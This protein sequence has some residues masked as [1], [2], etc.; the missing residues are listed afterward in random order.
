MKSGFDVKNRKAS[1]EFAVWHGEEAIKKQDCRSR[2]ADASANSKSKA[3]EQKKR[4]LET[5]RLKAEK[6]Y[7]DC[8]RD[9]VKR[10]CVQNFGVEERQ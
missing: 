7:E 5:A 1:Q 9:N 3:A 4:T 6:C 10:L 2:I 8:L